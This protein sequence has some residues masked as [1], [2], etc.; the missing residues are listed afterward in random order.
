M[1]SKYIRVSEPG[2]NAGFYATPT[3]GNGSLPVVFTDTSGNIFGTE[4]QYLY[5]GDGSVQTTVN[6]TT[7]SHTY[8]W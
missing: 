3:S 8:G 5:F 4:T 7:I 1:Q 6:S 2:P